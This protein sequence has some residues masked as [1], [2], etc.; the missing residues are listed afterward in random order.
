[1]R[2]GVWRPSLGL[3]TLK[4]L[5]HSLTMSELPSERAQEAEIRVGVMAPG[6]AMCGRGLQL[7][8]QQWG[9]AAHG[10]C[11]HCPLQRPCTIISCR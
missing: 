8:A 4:L 5:A 9:Q 10:I 3:C 6:Q 11:Q 7:S 2:G 1:M